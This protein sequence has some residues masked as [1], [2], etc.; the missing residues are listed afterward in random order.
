MG[1]PSAIDAYDMRGL[2]LVISAIAWLAGILLASVV[3]LPVLAWLVGAGGALIA[4]MLVRHRART[5][6][7]VFLVLCLCLSA[8]RY[9]SILPGN[10]PR[11][12][13][14]AIGKGALTVRGTVVAEPKVQ[15]HMRVLL[16]AATA[17]SRNNG[18]SW[19]VANGEIEVQTLGT[20]L[21]DP[22]GANYG[23]DVE[24][25]GKLQPALPHSVRSIFASMAFARVTVDHSGGNPVLAFLYHLRSTLADRIAQSLPQPAA[26]LLIAIVLS[27]HTPGLQPLTQAFSVTNTAHLIAPSG[28]K[29]TILAGLVASSARWLSAQRSRGQLPAQMQRDWRRWLVS[30]LVILTIAGYTI[31]SGAGAAA[32]R[33]GM[34]GTLLV[35]APRLNRSYNVYTALAFTAVLLSAVDPFVLWDSGFQL[36]FLGTLGIVLLTPLFQHLL[37]PLTRIPTGTY[38]AEVI[39][40]TLAAQTATLPI[41]GVTFHQLSLVAPLAN[42]LTV[43]LLG[44]LILLGLLVSGAGLVFA[45][46]ALVCGWV[47]WPLLWF[48]SA[49]VLWCAQL[50][51]AYLTIDTFGTALAWSYYALLALATAL[52]IQRYS[53]S[54]ASHTQHRQASPIPA[55]SPRLWRSIQ[56]GTALLIIATTGIMTLLPPQ[57]P[58]TI[59]FFDLH[60]AGQPGQGESIFIRTATGRTVLIDGG[61][62]AVA[63][64]QALN[65][66][67]PP[68]QHHLD[69]LILTSARLD[70]IT[71]LQDVLAR[72]SIDLVLD[73][74]MLHPTATYARWR[75][76]ISERAVRYL[77]AIQGTTIPIGSQAALQVLWPT[78]LLHKGSNEI[79]DNSLVLRLV[80]PGLHL[81]LLGTSVQSSYAL[82][83]LRAD[84]SAPFLQ[85]DI[86]QMMAEAGK[87]IPPALADVL[88]K[89]QPSLLVL[90]PAALTAQQRKN[91]VSSIIALPALLS[92]QGTHWHTVQTAQVGTLE[93]SSANAGWSMAF[94]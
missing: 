31:L 39:A 4:L 67:L 43:P 11:S 87:P 23:D 36:S 71:G 22:Y 9:S 84:I 37:H 51:G 65:T 30:L 53:R 78:A 64:T 59:T 35:I 82:A 73:A 80:A 17:I 46:L 54:P 79:N 21:D 12:I 88:T 25:N 20:L 90:T 44:P 13:T 60:P 70:H 34:M 63:L 1:E 29:V 27:L 83:G 40:V 85:A 52:L 58:F 3:T 74:G 38:L 6:L 55:L 66:Q 48:V 14:T 32:L 50:P 72:Y 75:R 49:T 7:M 86:V 15:G 77:T 8:W 28:F 45:P 26:A 16:V 92:G 5:R 24:L 94:T 91:G 93:V 18:A 10:D 33:A 19:K 68:W 81:L 2:T 56:V 62:D 69:M 41:F 61:L 76:T 57:Q 42:M 47:A 89:V